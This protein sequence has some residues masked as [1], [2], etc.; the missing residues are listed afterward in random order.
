MSY[1]VKPLRLDEH[2]EALARLWTENMSDGRISALVP[3][4][5]RWLYEQG[6]DGPPTTLLC[7]VAESGDVVGCGS[8][9]PRPTWIDGRRV[10]A[11]VLCDFAVTRNHRVLGA[12]LAIQRGLVDAARGAGLE[13]LYGYPN[14]KSLAVFKRIG[15]RVVGDTTTWVL[16]LRSGYKVRDVLPWRWAARLAAIPV[17]VGLALADRLRRLTIRMPARDEL[18]AALDGR[19]DALWA[20]ARA[21]YGIAG[22]RSRAYLE[23]RYARF[24]TIEHRFFGTFSSGEDRLAGYA[25][26]TV[27]AG[28]AVVRDL[29]ADREETSE[30]A[31]LLALAHRLRSEEVDALA[32]SHFGNPEFGER[33]RGAGFLRRPGSR[34]LVLHPDV[35]PEGLRARA[36]EPANWFML[37]GE[38]DI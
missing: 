35:V 26:F 5:M 12:A 7:V 4:R 9:F 34:P 15:Y 11:G 16:P 32:L 38:L 28:R 37:D 10:Q 3:S 25:V 31:L 22:E 36:L 8:Y 17:D 6:P 29:F 24:P 30:E 23:W 20:R 21:G 27:E 18:P 2:R 14:E 33:L 13:L 19:A 1:A